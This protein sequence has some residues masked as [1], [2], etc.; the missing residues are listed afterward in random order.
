VLVR[1]NASLRGDPEA[2]KKLAQDRAKTAEKYLTD[3][4]IDSS[5]VRA[6]GVEPSGRTA[7]TFLLGEPPY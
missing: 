4:G 5:R 1:G 6:V 2:N 7:V 3:G